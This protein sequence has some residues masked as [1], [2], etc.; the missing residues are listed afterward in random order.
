MLCRGRRFFRGQGIFVQ[1]SCPA[2]GSCRGNDGFFSFIPCL[3]GFTLIVDRGLTV[4]LNAAQGH[5]FLMT[6]AAF[7]VV[8]LLVEVIFVSALLWVLFGFPVLSLHL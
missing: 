2:G 4:Q 8:P 5:G 6:S 1:P 3:C 7:E